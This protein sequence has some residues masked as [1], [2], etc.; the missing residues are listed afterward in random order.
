M[1]ERLGLAYKSYKNDFNSLTLS[2]LVC[3]DT[4]FSIMHFITHKLIFF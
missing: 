4:I 3:L 1:C 2:D